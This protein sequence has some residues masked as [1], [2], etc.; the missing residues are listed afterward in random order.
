M[1]AYA[2]PLAIAAGPQQPSESGSG[3]IYFATSIESPKVHEIEANPHV[4]VTFQGKARWA[5]IAGR[6]SG[7]R[8]ALIDRLWSD[9]WRVFFPD[10]RA[11]KLLCILAVTPSAGE[12]WDDRG[13]AGVRSSSRSAIACATGCRLETDEAH[14]HTKVQPAMPR[15]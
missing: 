15:K 8:P 13:M 1:A 3:P 2:R 10:G 14:D 11:D 5:V 7:A 12:Y 6:G 9:D 4:L